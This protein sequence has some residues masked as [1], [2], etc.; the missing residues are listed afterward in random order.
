MAYCHVDKSYRIEPASL[1]LCA[2]IAP[3]LRA[4]DKA[5][6]AASHPHRS[7]RV[8]LEMFY[9]SSSVCLGIYLH[10]KLAALCGLAATARTNTAC[11]WLLSSSAAA[12]YPVAYFRAVKHCLQ[13]ALRN[14]ENLFNFA[15]ERYTAAHRLVTHLGGTVHEAFVRCGKTK[16]LLFT[17]RRKNMGGI[18]NT[19][20][21][22]VSTAL[23][24]FKQSSS[25][26]RNYQRLAGQQ[27]QA[28]Q[29]A[30]QTAAAQA[31]YLFE[32]AAE[33]TRR[34]Y[35]QALQQASSSQA[36]FAAKGLTPSSATLDTLLRQNRLQTQL[37]HAYLQDALQ[38]ELSTQAQNLA[39]ELRALGEQGR[40]YEGLSRR[41]STLA[42]L[43]QAFLSWFK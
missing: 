20:S 34:L 36:S 33:K 43:G 3:L 25:A 35:E 38:S 4:A 18:I 37:N 14:Y 28:L 16:F 10:G 27:Q 42:K 6:L 23:A 40:R 39:G 13:E 11:V 5:E 2:Q 9:K 12:Q 1:A 8:C 15:D 32:S 22:N 41:K 19:T 17:F 30:R 7:A 26:Q 24:A 29:E 21:G 31:D